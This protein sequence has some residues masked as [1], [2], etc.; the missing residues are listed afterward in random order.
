[1]KGLVT[2]GSTNRSIKLGIVANEFFDPTLSRV[3]GFGML[4]RQIAR[5]AERINNPQLAVHLYYGSP[6]N[7]ANVA[8]D[9]VY[10][11]PMHLAK[12][13]WR[14]SKY[15]ILL[16]GARP[17]VWLSI[18]YRANYDYFLGMFKSVPLIVWVQD[19][20]TPEDW[21]RIRTS[22]VP[23]EEGIEPKGLGYIDCSPL[24]DLV[25]KRRAAGAKTIFVVP[26]G[27]LTKK[28]EATYAVVPDEITELCYPME[29]IPGPFA[30]A[31]KPVVTFLGRL[32][33]QKRPWVAAAIAERMPDVCFQFLGK[34]HFTGPGSWSTENLPSNV[35]L[36]GHVDGDEKLKH[37]R[38]TWV[39][40]NTSIHEGLPISFVEG[41]QCEA[42][43][44]ACVDPEKVV[45]NFGTYVGEYRGS[46][47]QGVEV[48]V[49]ALR[50]IIDSP[51]RRAAL[52]AAGRKWVETHHSQ[53][54][55]A[56]QL[57]DICAGLSTHRP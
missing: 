18:D 54:R 15:K 30:K 19:P 14:L 1:M 25:R 12:G 43:I 23:G 57:S 42:P 7:E 39:M 29:P 49:D 20:K 36:V 21:E 44:V 37:L 34:S 17:D 16:T 8:L 32:D 22:F 2:V 52:G 48:F 13:P 27:F 55:F 51:E 5:C 40:L 38:A 4:S 50:L 28:I 31:D 26:T 46:G 35:K 6:P 3:G 33:P 47:M 45:S 11:R 10:G 24:A 53:Q 56:S 9:Q 41:L